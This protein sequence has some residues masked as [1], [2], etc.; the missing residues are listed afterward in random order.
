MIVS[1]Y[2]LYRNEAPLGKVILENGTT[3]VDVQDPAVRRDVTEILSHPIETYEGDPTG[4]TLATR[5][6]TIPP[7]TPRF[8]EA[9]V[10]P[11][12]DIGVLAVMEMPRSPR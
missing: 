11:L 2:T 3:R 8:L 6:V 4:R 5:R 7:N 1:L 10:Y 12:R 9:A